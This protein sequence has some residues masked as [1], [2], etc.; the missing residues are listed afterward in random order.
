MLT[1]HYRSRIGRVIIPWGELWQEKFAAADLDA[2]RGNCLSMYLLLVWCPR[3]RGRGTVA[4][5]L[6]GLFPIR[7][8]RWISS[9]YC[10]ERAT[11]CPNQR[12]CLVV[13]LAK[14]LQD[15]AFSSPWASEWK[16]LFNIV[17]LRL[18]YLCMRQSFCYQANYNPYLIFRPI[19]GVVCPLFVGGC[20]YYTLSK[21]LLSVYAIQAW[22][23]RRRQN[24]QRNIRP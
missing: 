14:V 3:L 8:G 17:G 7:I 12:I 23:M 24:E 21:S 5:F 15:A 6:L 1:G 4:F 11:P 10:L 13:F 22:I 20:Y 18:W 2:C 19:C 9:D 16:I